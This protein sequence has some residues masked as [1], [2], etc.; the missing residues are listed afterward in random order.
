MAMLL[1]LTIR[2]KFFTRRT[3]LNNSKFIYLEFEVKSKI[4]NITMENYGLSGVAQTLESH[5]IRDADLIFE[6]NI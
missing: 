6:N 5:Q 1:L 2:L 4:N 3:N